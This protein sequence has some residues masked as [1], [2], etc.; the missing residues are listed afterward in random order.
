MTTAGTLMEI[1]QR[2]YKCFG[3]QYWWPAREPFEVIV[4]AILTQNTNWINVERAIANLRKEKVLT[5]KRLYQMET[6]G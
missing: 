6:T 2:L 4:G 5:P 1:Y 3:P